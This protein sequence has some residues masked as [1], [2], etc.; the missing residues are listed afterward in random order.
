LIERLLTF[1]GDVLVS[2][3]NIWLKI[4]T[5]LQELFERK[6]LEF[7]SEPKKIICGGPMMGVALD[8]LDY[9]ILKG[10]G[11]FLFLSKFYSEEESPCIKCARCVD[12]CPVN[13]LPLEYAKRVK[14][15]E[16]DNLNEFNIQD[17]IECGCCAYECPAKIPLLHY[18]KIGKKYVIDN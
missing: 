16:Y 15:E 10:T 17:C 11:G 9:P 8:S 6:I 5:T 4:G 2:S 14:Q 18:I 13:L 12:A 7:R 3:K 1:A